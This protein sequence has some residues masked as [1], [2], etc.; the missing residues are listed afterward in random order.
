[1]S[2]KIVSNLVALLNARIQNRNKERVNVHARSVR[3]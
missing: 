3:E 2:T 1:M